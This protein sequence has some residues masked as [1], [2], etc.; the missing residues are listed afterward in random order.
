MCVCV[1]VCVCACICIHVCVCVCV[2]VCACVCACVCVCVCVC[3]C[4]KY[5]L[6]YQHVMVGRGVV[7]VVVRVAGDADEVMTVV[8]E[9]P[10]ECPDT[11][12]FAGD[13]LIHCG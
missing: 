5:G 12:F 13:I 9:H 2:C 3:V 1:C 10:Q 6:A 11:L 7:A 8:V 4:A